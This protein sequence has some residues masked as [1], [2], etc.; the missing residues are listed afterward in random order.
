MYMDMYMYMHLH[1]WKERDTSNLYTNL[2]GITK[3]IIPLLNVEIAKSQLHTC[4]Y[5]QGKK[6]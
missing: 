5:T 3:L 1:F 4:I 6:L 2:Y